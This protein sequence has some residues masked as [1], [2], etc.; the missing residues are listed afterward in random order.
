MRI[1]ELLA[2]DDPMF[3]FEF[4]PP[5]TPE[6]VSQLFETIEALKPLRPDYVSVTYGA[7]GATRDGTVE[8]ATRIRRDHGIEAMAHV[9]CVGETREG[10]A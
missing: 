2:R 1:D 10:L 6:G 5:K 7:G 3:S 9:S 8:I 4:F